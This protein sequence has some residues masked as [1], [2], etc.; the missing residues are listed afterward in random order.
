MGKIKNVKQFVLSTLERLFKTDI[1]YVL[2]GGSWLALSQFALSGS[3]FLLSIAFAHFLPRDVYGLYKYVLSIVAI[4]AITTLTGVDTALTR[5]VAQGSEGSIYDALRVKLRYGMLGT[6]LG[7]GLALYYFTHGNTFLG[8]GFIIAAIVL[9]LWESF[10]LYGSYLNG[11]GLFKV[12][13][14]YYALTQVVSALSIFSALFFTKDIIVILATYFI[15][16]TFIRIINFF[17]VIRKIQP[18]DQKDSG[19][20]SYGKHLSAINFIG[21]VLGQLDQILVFH[22][23][24][25]AELAV[26]ALAIAPVEHLKGLLKNVQALAFPR[27]A[28]RTKEDVRTNIFSKAI[29]LGIFVGGITFCYI[30]IAPFFYKI[31]FPKY[32]DATLYSQI[33]ALSLVGVAVNNFLNTFLESQAQEKKLMQSNLF[34]IINI[35]IIFPFI[36]YFGLMGAVVGRLLGRF[37]SLLVTII[38]IKKISFNPK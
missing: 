17:L 30:V 28:A 31:F 9:P 22:Y 11:K 38:I 10:D 3:T 2:R 24:G 26:Y 27:F 33:I 32:I 13:A 18:N 4:L 8:T 34:G 15:A 35:I 19:M 29:R 20:V 21:V 25:A 7:V 36:A 5:A 1:R 37:V 14:K 16:N 12:Y 23:I 6:L